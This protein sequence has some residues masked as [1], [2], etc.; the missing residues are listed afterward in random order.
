MKARYTNAPI[1]RE[2]RDQPPAL[3]TLAVMTVVLV[4]MFGIKIFCSPADGAASAVA[5]AAQSG[6]GHETGAA[7]PG[8]TDDGVIAVSADP[9][10]ADDP[11]LACMASGGSAVPHEGTVSSGFA[12]RSDPFD[13]GKTDFH[14]GIDIAGEGE[15]RAWS[16]G[17][18]SAA[19]ESESYGN[20]VTV[21]H[22]D[23][24]TTLYAHLESAA[25][26]EGDRL[27]AGDLIGIA[28]ST[29]D[30]TGVHLH[31]E[32]QIDGEPVDPADY[33]PWNG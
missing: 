17:T 30:S 10:E 20:Y 26:A 27:E 28:G 24:V 23:R 21:K 18:V 1:N 13:A 22:S 12:V 14:R 32:I 2:V 11:A 6:A 9:A 25:C 15:V 8:R 4:M 29:G 19:G 31:F 7:T 33:M 3:K 5:V 16:A